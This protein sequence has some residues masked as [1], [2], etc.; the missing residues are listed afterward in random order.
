MF[1]DR[2]KLLIY[3]KKKENKYNLFNMIKQ[4]LIKNLDI[5]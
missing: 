3:D 1:K 5:N 2:S 4:N